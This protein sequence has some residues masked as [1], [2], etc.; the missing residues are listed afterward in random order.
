VADERPQ[1]LR[2]APFLAGGGGGDAGS[3]PEHALDG[4]QR[5][6]PI[7]GLHGDEQNRQDRDRAPDEAAR[8]SRA[9][10]VGVRAEHGRKARARRITRFADTELEDLHTITFADSA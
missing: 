4:R 10:D 6:L 1:P 8:C 9:L 5:Q 2:R 3:Q 7:A